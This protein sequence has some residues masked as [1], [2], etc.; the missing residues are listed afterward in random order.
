MT[1]QNKTKSGI[2]LSNNNHTQQS[3]VETADCNA[4]WAADHCHGHTKRR[5][6]TCQ[7]YTQ[8]QIEFTKAHPH[9]SSVVN[10]NK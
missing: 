1:T 2:P 7:R 3:K 9:E 4:C 8:S 10:I 5:V 6:C